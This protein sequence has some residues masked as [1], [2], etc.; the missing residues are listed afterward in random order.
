[1]LKSQDDELFEAAINLG[2]FVLRFSTSVI[3]E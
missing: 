2:R 1:M 3:A